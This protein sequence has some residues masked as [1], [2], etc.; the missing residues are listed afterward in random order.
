MSTASCACLGGLE[1]VHGVASYPSLYRQISVA[2]Q[3]NRVQERTVIRGDGGVRSVLEKQILLERTTKSGSR[4]SP[5]K[6]VVRPLLQ[7]FG[8]LS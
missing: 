8:H 3:A 1:P 7:V 2:R 5:A 4:L 6:C